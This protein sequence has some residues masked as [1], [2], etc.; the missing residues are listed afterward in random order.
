MSSDL[1]PIVLTA[2]KGNWQAFSSRQSNASFRELA[3]AVYKRDAY[4]CRYCGFESQQFQSVVNIDQNYKNNALSN[5]ATACSLCAPCFFLD[6]VGADGQYGGT[7]IYLPE[8][9][10]ADLNHFCRALFC[11]MLRESPYKGKLQAVYLSLSDR[12]QPLETIFGP[13]TQHPMHFGQA[14][15]DADLD[16]TQSQHPLLF[17]LKLLPIRKYFNNEATYWKSTVFANIPL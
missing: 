14:L 12:S 8:I 7:L 4:T 15:I 9:S 5:L 10:Q 16:Q 2:I 3:L 1:L 6:S 13:G 17:D 11:S